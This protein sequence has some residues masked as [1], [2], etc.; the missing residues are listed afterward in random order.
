MIQTLKKSINWL[1]YNRNL[2]FLTLTAFL[3][4][5]YS[6]VFRVIW[7]PFALS[8]GASITFIGVLGSIGTLDGGF[9][10]MLIQPLGGWLGDRIGRKSVLYISSGI[11]ILSFMF[12]LLAGAF[13][14]IWLLIPAVG[15]IGLSAINRPSRSAMVSESVEETRKGTAFSIVSIAV[16]FPGIITAIL[17]G[18]LYERFGYFWIFVVSILLECLV[19]GL[20]FKG[21]RETLQLRTRDFEKLKISKVLIGFFSPNKDLLY[22]Y[23]FNVCDGIAWSIT[24]TILYSM[25]IERFNYSITQLGILTSVLF[26][27]WTI[28]QL[29]IGK[30]MDKIGARKMLIVCEFLGIP[31]AFIWVLQPSFSVFVLS[32]VL[33]GLTSASFV[34][35]FATLLS[36]HVPSSH[37][38]QEFGKAA[39]FRGLI[40]FSMPAL[41]GFLYSKWG[42]AAPPIATLLFSFISLLVVLLLVKENKV[43]SSNSI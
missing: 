23:L 15:L 7:Q 29:P 9:F 14:I 6:S 37:L 26:L 38:A 11:I 18:A 24:P 22:I 42:F 40:S 8:L 27:S 1:P 43:L 12:L 31:L 17:G 16:V 2:I 30:I 5:V 28:F 36:N 41:G 20:V 3:V 10:T 33:F 13:H 4:G 35:S 21:I 25:L 39:G 19:V 32:Q 34:P